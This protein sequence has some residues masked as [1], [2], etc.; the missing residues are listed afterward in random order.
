MPVTNTGGGFQIICTMF[1]ASGKALVNLLVDHAAV[2]G[3]PAGFAVALAIDTGAV[4]RAGG[5]QA[6]SYRSKYCK[7]VLLWSFM[8][9]TLKTIYVY[10]IIVNVKPC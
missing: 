9:Q 4:S 6:I 3:L 10:V 8:A 1:R 7:I 5:V 2:L